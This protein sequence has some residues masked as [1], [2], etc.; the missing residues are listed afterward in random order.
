MLLALAIGLFSLRV[1]AIFFAMITL[2]VASAFQVLA[3]QMSWLTGGE[4]GRS[5][6]LPELLRPG[7]VLISK[8]TFGFE[9]NGRTLTYYLVFAASA[10]MILM[11]LRVVNSPFGRVLQAIRENRFRAEALGYRTVFH[12][13]YANCIAALVAASAGVL[14]AL[15]LRYAGPDT[16]LSFSI[17]LDILLMVV[18]GGMGTMYGAIIG[19]T[20]FILAQNYLQTLMGTA[21]RAAADAGLP[22]LPGLLHPDRWLLW[23]GVLFIASVYFFPTGVVGRLRGKP[24]AAK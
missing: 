24:Q 9:I 15:W 14:N 17:M 21:S 13:T 7:T 12:L 1:A 16:S 19:A 6:Q 2:A 22:L 4:D 10:L 11:L 3:S 18:I 5:F 20:I 8:A 23:L